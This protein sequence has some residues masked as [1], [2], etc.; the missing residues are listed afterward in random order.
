MPT[1]VVEPFI[2]AP[3]PLLL[4]EMRADGVDIRQFD[5]S[6]DKIVTRKLLF[7]LRGRGVERI[8]H[9]IQ[10]LISHIVTSVRLAGDEYH[11]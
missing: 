9:R 8:L 6:R 7:L 10:R 2:A 5:R 4:S 11:T 3:P 1:G